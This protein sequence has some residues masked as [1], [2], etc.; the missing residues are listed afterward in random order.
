MRR[1]LCL[2]LG[3]AAAGWVRAGGLSWPTNQFL[4]TFAT[5]ASVID[6]ID[7]STASGPEADLF[8]SLEGLVNRAQ[9]RIACVYNSAEEGKFTWLTLHGLGY[10]LIDGYI[11]ILKYR[12]NVTGLV[13]TDPGQPDTLNLATTI[14]GLKNELICDPSLLSKLTNSPYYLTIKD[15]LRGKFA[16]FSIRITGRNVRIESSPAWKPAGM[17]IC[18]ITWSRSSRQRSG[19]TQAPRQMRQP[20][21]R[22]WRT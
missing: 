14:A 16:S 19:W 8:T 18:G 9:P 12:T 6:C 15:D 20:W 3:L 1:L 11:A 17:D 7:I 22:S 10:S 5:P 13:V 21:P 2:C 4:P